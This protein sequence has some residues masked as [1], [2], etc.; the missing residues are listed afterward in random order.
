[1][2]SFYMREQEKS[3]PPII[4]TSIELFSLEDVNRGIKK[5]AN[6][7]AQDIYGFQISFWT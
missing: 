5:L 3:S 6:G 4:N 1:M 2:Q 7:K